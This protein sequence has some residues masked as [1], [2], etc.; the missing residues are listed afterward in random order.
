[1]AVP[2]TQLKADVDQIS[3]AIMKKELEGKTYSPTVAT[4]LA[5]KISTDIIGEMK[6]KFERYKFMLSSLVLQKGESGLSLSGA[7]L[8]DSTKDTNTVIMQENEHL[9]VIVNIFIVGI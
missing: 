6:G 3:T 7:C 5:N 8:W 2:L 4:D 9:I 1:M